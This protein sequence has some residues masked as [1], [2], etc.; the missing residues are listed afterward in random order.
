MFV[1]LIIGLIVSI[2]AIV[3][4]LHINTGN[5]YHVGY[6]TATETTGIFFKTKRAYIKTDIQSSQE[7]SYCVLDEK[8]FEKLK[9]A[10][11]TKEKIELSYFSWLSSG[12]ASCVGESDIIDGIKVLTK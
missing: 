8:V 1:V 10:A 3:I 7:D 11:Q 6:V 5:G 2:G 12:I 4:G 9:E